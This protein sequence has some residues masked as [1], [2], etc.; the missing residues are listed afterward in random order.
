[1]RDDVFDYVSRFFHT[2]A[3]FGAEN[4]LFPAFGDVC[5]LLES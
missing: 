3:R 5:D 1:L 2:C 4:Y